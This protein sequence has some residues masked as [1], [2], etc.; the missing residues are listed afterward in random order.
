MVSTS[1]AATVSPPIVFDSVAILLPI[2]RNASGDFDSSGVS[3]ESNSLY[4]STLCAAEPP[5]VF[6]V[7]RAYFSIFRSPSPVS[8]VIAAKS[9]S[10]VSSS[11]PGWYISCRDDD[12]LW[13][14]RVIS[15]KRN[16]LV[17]ISSTKEDNLDTFLVICCA[18]PAR[19]TMPSCAFPLM[20][21][22]KVT[23]SFIVLLL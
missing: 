4:D 19:L 2:F 22:K 12:R 15:L 18:L 10:D 21:I 7:S 8:P 23:V 9:V 17:P 11:M 3:C 6:A 5:K 1:A 14:P 16:I 13:I 20:L